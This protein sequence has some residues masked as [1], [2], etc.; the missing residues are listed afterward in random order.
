MAAA[1]CLRDRLAGTRAEIVLGLAE[2]SGLP[3]A[4]ATVVYGEAM[5]S[6]QSQEQKNRIA[7]EAR[8]L[9][10]PGGRYG[11]H[12]LCYSPDDLS[13]HLITGAESYLAK[14]GKSMKRE[15][16]ALCQRDCWRNIPISPTTGS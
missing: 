9:L 16:L 3:G 1:D 6:M 10:A 2:Q 7:A 14:L 11:I 13:D 8:R 15:K 4:C 5:L 12:E